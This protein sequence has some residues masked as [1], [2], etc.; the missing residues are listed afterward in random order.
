MNEQVEVN[1]AM[2]DRPEVLMRLFHPRSETGGTIPGPNCTHLMIPVQEDIAIGAC[3]HLAEENAPNIL[4]FH[5]NGEIVADY[6][7]IGALYA[8]AGINFLP[9]DYRGYGRSGGSPTMSAII[10][11]CHVILD[12]ATTWLL[13]NEFTGPLV[14]MGRSLGS[15]SALELAARRQDEFTGMILESGYAYGTPLLELFGI[16]VDNAADMEE[17]VFRHIQKINAFQKPALIIHAEYDHIIPFSDGRALF[18]AC[19]SKNKTFLKIPGADHNDILFR[20]LSEYMAAIN[21]FIEC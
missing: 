13:E 17:K 11:D 20:G 1:Y 21:T 2:L 3:F 8:Q 12:F 9:V 5:G 6:H 19:G 18:E 10:R 7:D 16:Q 14:V 4:F 15:A